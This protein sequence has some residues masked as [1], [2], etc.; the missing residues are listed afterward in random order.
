MDSA[1]RLT[2]RRALAIGA[3]A[4]GVVVVGGAVGLEL[5]DH[6]VLPGKSLLDQLDGACDVTV[7]AFDF[8]PGETTESASFYSR[9]RQRAVRYSVGYPPG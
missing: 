6:G 9:Y 2:R 7:P 5:V 3:G 1:R 8:R 4:L